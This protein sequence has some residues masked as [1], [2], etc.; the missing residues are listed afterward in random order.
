MPIERPRLLPEPDISAM[1]AGTNMARPSPASSL[2]D[3]NSSAPLELAATS[4][5]AASREMPQAATLSLPATSET[6]PQSG[7][8]RSISD[9]D[10][11]MRDTTTS[12]APRDLAW[13]IR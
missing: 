11:V 2:D 10:V 5:D 13:S 7:D 4:D 1:T 9:E 6:W 8:V 3:M 12:D